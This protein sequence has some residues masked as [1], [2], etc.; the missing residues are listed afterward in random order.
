[1]LCLYCLLHWAVIPILFIRLGNFANPVAVVI[2]HIDALLL[3][4]PDCLKLIKTNY[5][6]TG[7]LYY[8]HWAVVP[9]S[10]IRLGNSGNQVAIVIF[11]VVLLFLKKADC[12]KLITANCVYNTKSMQTGFLHY[13]YVYQVHTQGGIFIF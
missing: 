8:K 2:F 9:V 12:W 7:F 1:M 6:P 3:K 11:P 10:S 13:N 4:N 5:V